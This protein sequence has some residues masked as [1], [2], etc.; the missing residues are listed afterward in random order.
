MEFGIWCL[1]F[2]LLA[3]SNFVHKRLEPGIF[4]DRLPGRFMFQPVQFALALFPG[5]IQPLKCLLVISHLG[6]KQTQAIGEAADAIG[7]GFEVFYKCVD[8]ILPA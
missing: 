6:I 2:A 1:G 7:D 5:Y 8:F 3:E 4:P